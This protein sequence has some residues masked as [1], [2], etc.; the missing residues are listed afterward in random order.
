M[1]RR[2][3]TIVAAVVLCLL[4]LIGTAWGEDPANTPPTR[5]ATA[6]AAPATTL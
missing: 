3:F 1:T 6:P 2:V 5:S 4:P